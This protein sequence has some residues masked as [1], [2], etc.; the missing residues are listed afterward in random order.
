MEYDVSGRQLELAVECRP[1][2]ANGPF[3]QGSAEQELYLLPAMA[4][5]Y[6]MADGGRL[7]AGTVEG[8]GAE[9]IWQPLTVGVAVGYRNG[10]RGAEPV[11]FIAGPARHP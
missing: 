7:Y 1:C 11:G 8:L 6:P 4:A 3:D 9:A 10:L 5:V 2:H